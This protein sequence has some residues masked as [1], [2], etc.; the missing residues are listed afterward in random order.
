MTR[1]AIGRPGAA[2]VL[3]CA[4]QFMLVLDIAVVNVGLPSIQSAL[5]FSPGDLQLVVTAYAVTF[6]GL[7]LLGGR[8]ADL[9]GRRRLFVAGLVVFTAASLGCGLARSDAMLVF[10]RALQGVGGAL[11]SPAALSLLIAIFPEGDERSRALGIWAGVGAGGAAAG[12]LVGGVLTDVAGWRWIFLIN[13]PVGLAAVLA[14]RTLLPASAGARAGRIDLAGATAATAGL[15]A[16][17][18]GLGRGQQAGF[19]DGSTV[20]LLIAAGALLAAF[21]AIER[22]VREPL[23]DFAIFRARTLSGANLVLGLGAGVF[24]AA[25]F[26]L[27][28]YFQ[29]VLGFS[30]IETGLA[31][32]PISVLIGATAQV[33]SRAI[34]RAGARRLMVAG[35]ITLAAGVALLSG[36][37]PGGSYLADALPGMLAVAVAMGLVFPVGTVA[38]TA[39][40]QPHQQGLASGILGT[41]QQLGPAIALAGLA[42]IASG[43]TADPAGPPATALTDGF[44]TALLVAAAV[45]ALAALGALALI[46]E[47]DCERELARRRRAEAQPPAV[48][49]AHASPCQPAIVQ[50]APAGSAS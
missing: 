45:A 34:A 38:A 9:H 31:F 5:E 14:A 22:R 47:R 32:L 21:A 11:V 29:Q 36:I 20:A 40:V 35:A 4:A 41:S 16:L 42:S 7:L 44:Q 30:P 33:A 24:V 13:V 8:A 3:L 23:V 39:G 15:M 27:T 2:L 10:A 19:T 26:F 25:T 50:G 12:L 49:S 48:L 37:S 17:V 1:A 6:G 46:R 28:L 43:I 18:Y